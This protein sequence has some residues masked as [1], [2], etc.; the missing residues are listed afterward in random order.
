[1]LL[2]ALYR[3]RKHAKTACSEDPV[4]RFNRQLMATMIDWLYILI[5]S[6]RYGNSASR[7]ISEVLGVIWKQ[8]T[9]FKTVN[10]PP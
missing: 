10:Y 7:I 2:K 9:R 5:G 6:R 3:P 1:M 8:V 4:T